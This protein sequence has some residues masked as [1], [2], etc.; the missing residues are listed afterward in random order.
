MRETKILL[1]DIEPYYQIRI[2]P[3]G[4]T[5]SMNGI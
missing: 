2:F 4:K 3:N 5:I 1:F